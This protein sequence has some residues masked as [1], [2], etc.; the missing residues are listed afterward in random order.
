VFLILGNSPASEFRRRGITQKKSYNMSAIGYFMYS[1]FNIEKF[2]HSGHRVCFCDYYGSQSKH[3]VFSFSCRIK[4]LVS[5]IEMGCVYCTVQTE[6][7]NKMQTHF[8]VKG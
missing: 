3:L 1:V 4:L 7:L 8:R 5:L 6:D 2:T